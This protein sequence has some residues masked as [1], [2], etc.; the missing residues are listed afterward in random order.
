MELTCWGL[1]H[2]FAYVASLRAYLGSETSTRYILDFHTEGP[3]QTNTRI[4][5]HIESMGS[6][7]YHKDDIIIAI[8]MTNEW[9]F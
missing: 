1:P 8:K 5:Y 2:T 4:V 3:I 6:Y 7:L 9:Y